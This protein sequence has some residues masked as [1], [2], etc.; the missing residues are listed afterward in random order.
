MK[1][2]LDLMF[3]KFINRVYMRL[4][5]IG[6]VKA[7]T[8]NKQFDK[9]YDYWKKRAEEEFNYFDDLKFIKEHNL[10][11]IYLILEPLEEPEQI[12]PNNYSEE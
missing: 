2:L 4:K 11:F 9:V 10:V 12:D 1:K 8:F 7:T 6:Y 5:K 3:I